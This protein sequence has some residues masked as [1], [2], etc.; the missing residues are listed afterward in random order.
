[1]NPKQRIVEDIVRHLDS[2][3]LTILARRTEVNASKD[4]GILHFVQRL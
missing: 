3:C 4:S 1:M 2:S